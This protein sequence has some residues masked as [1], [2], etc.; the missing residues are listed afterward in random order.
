[1]GVGLGSTSLI[2][3]P[4]EVEADIKGIYPAICPESKMQC[5]HI[6]VKKKVQGKVEKMFKMEFE[7]ITNSKKRAFAA[8]GGE[9]EDL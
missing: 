5:M 4:F 8:Y 1:M 7:E 6:L 9:D 2:P 3:L